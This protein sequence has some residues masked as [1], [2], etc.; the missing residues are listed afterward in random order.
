VRVLSEKL[1]FF[2]LLA[3]CA[4]SVPAQSRPGNA[5]IRGT[6]RDPTGTV[7]PR[8]SVDITGSGSG[9]I[10]R[11]RTDAAGR[12]DSGDLPR[13]KYTVTVFCAGFASFEREIDLTTQPSAD[14]HVRLDVGKSGSVS[15]E[16]GAKPAP[17]I[18]NRLDSTTT[19]SEI[20]STITRLMFA[21]HV[22]GM[23][24]ALFND[25]RVVYEKAYGF[26][27]KE[28]ALPL[29]PDSV[30]TAASLSKAT[31]AY[32]VMQLVQE[33]VIDLDKPV[34]QYLPKPL[35]EYDDYKDLS[36]DAR[37][38][39][40]T[41]RMLLDHTAGFPNLRRFTD[42]KKLSI[43]FE[44]GKRFAYSGEG[45]K[46]LQFVVETLTGKTLEQLMQERIFEPFGMTRT[47]MVWQPRFE[48]D[49]ANAYDE[50]EHSLGPQ[51]RT[52]ANAAG[53]MQTTL[54]DFAKL[55]DAVAHGE[56]L[57][58]ETKKLMLTP[59]IAIHSKHEFPS[60]AKETTKENDRIR[61]SYGLGWGLYFTP[62]G[63]AFFKEGHDDGFRHYVV[64]FD[65][66]GKGLLIMSNSANTEGIYEE[67][68]EKLLGDTYTPI[69]WEGFK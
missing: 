19:S 25:G 11:I 7:V 24:I 54:A 39:K 4:V 1:G 14:L 58:P 52:I 28:K 32:M 44:P 30:M 27:D 6:V 12:F 10:E 65:E 57:K 22:T 67:L 34:Y 49:F 62:Y 69:E 51:R 40:I 37:Y 48:S 38:K 33:G 45:I 36:G 64:Y 20:D 55:I 59:Q 61:L 2:L 5:R 18:L 63:E 53:G 3:V 13:G 42:D 15:V 26:R 66:A 29:T 68:L 21:A 60:L 41:A 31:F 9:H 43:D 56:G 47:S 16:L 8:A 23:G 46:L 35:P 50:Q 17:Q